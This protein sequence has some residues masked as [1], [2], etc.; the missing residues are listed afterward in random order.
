MQAADIDGNGT[1]DYIQFRTAM[2]QRHKL[3][4]FEISL[5][6]L[7]VD[8]LGK[9]FKDYGMGDDATIATIKEIMSEDDRDKDGRISY[10]EF[11]SMRNPTVSI[12]F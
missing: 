11:R 7:P 1:I 4:R 9:A 5:Q 10:D 12:V 2:M 6:S 3:E 8:E